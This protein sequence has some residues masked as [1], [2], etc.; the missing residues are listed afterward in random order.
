MPPIDEKPAEKRDPA[1]KAGVG[2]PKIVA[3]GKKP[4]FDAK[5]YL[6]RTLHRHPGEVLKVVQIP[7]TDSFR[8]NWYDPALS[9]T[10]AIPGLS[11]MY[12]RASKFMF[13][14]LGPDG[15]PLITYPAR[16]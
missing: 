1:E 4:V 7:H 9:H 5:R 3:G 6:E 10:A 16:Q 15:N 2:D 12:I 8:V 13:C 14:R 11:I